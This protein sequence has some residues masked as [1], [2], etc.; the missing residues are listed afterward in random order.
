MAKHKYR[1]A[2]EAATEALQVRCLGRS[3]AV[4]ESTSIERMPEASTLVER[5]LAQGMLAEMVLVERM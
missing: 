2:V 3:S 4:V 1:S 5:K